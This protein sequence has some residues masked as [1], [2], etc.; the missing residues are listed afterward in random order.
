HNLVSPPLQDVAT[1]GAVATLEFLGVSIA[2]EG[3]VLVLDDKTTLAVAEACSGLRMLTAFIVVAATFVAFIE[4]PLWQR[5]ALLLSSIPIAILCNIARLTATAL[6]FTGRGPIDSFVH[7]FA[8]ICMMPM[9][10]VLL[11]IESRIL[12]SLVIDDER[13][14]TDSP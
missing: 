7:D 14:S 8:G 12:S 1:A 11:V 10:L 13:P 3:N 2:R 6:L 5:T 9:A 4:R